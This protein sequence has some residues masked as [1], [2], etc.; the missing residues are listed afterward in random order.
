MKTYIFFTRRLINI[1]GAEQYLYN[2]KNFLERQGWRV[3]IF[4]GQHGSILINDF[5]GF[6]KY[7]Y[8]ELYCVPSCFTRK[9]VEKNINRIVS[10]I[11]DCNGEECVIESVYMPS[12][13]WA[14]MVASRIK[15]RHLAFPLQERHIYD[16][17]AKKYLWFKYNRHELAGI[18]RDSVRQMLG[19]D[20]VELRDDVRISASCN[21]VFDDCDDPYSKLLD[22]K[23]DYTFGSIGRLVKPCVPAIVE[24][25]CSYAR[26]HP[27]KRF[28]V[29]MIGGSLVKGKEYDILKQLSSVSNIHAVM[30]GDVYPI[31]RSFASKIDVFVSTAGAATATYIE[32]YPTVKVN[33]INGEPIGVTG[34]DYM[35]GEKNMYASSADLSIEKCIDNAILN[36][37]KIRFVRGNGNEYISRMNT[38]FQR[39]LSFLDFTEKKEYYDAKLLM[40]IKQPGTR[41]PG[42]NSILGHILG[43]DG[44]EKLRRFIGK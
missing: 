30:T 41:F 44:Y 42:V 13:L 35:P 10:D 11:G 34:L 18:V 17:E 14:E 36:K 25:F 38:E 43:G 21:N 22:P 31:P 5:K 2:K 6:E 29:V 23:A 19:D 33:P 8:T 37:D 9:A 12:S 39:Q 3:L 4:S 7:I 32:K 15:A 24:G 40:K 27:D 28:N 26:N 20:S 1:G 16:E